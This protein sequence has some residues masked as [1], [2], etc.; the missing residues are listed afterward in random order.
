MDHRAITVGG[1]KDYLLL[2][3][4]TFVSNFG[5]NLLAGSEVGV[6]D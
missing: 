6:V 1:E 5:K 2:Q 3:G 4:I